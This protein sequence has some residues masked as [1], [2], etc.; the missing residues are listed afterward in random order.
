MANPPGA[1]GPGAPYPQWYVNLAPG[2]D[3]VPV[4]VGNALSKAIANTVNAPFKLVYFTSQSAAQA[5]A[6][7]NG[8]S[9]P[10]LPANITNDVNNAVNTSTGTVTGA[11]SAAATVGDFLGR[12]EEPQTWLRITEVVLGGILLIVAIKGIVSPV[13]TP[14]TNS[15][16]SGAK[17]AVKVGA[18]F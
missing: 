1:A 6:N 3:H 5:Y 9:H 2:T 7:A 12:L 15:V 14:I 13:T 8:G 16:K 4:K 18:F 11:V 17:T 10:I